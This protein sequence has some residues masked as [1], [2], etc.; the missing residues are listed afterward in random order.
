MGGPVAEPLGA[1]AEIYAALRT[2]L[3]DYTDKNGFERVVF[4]LSGGIDSALVAM[5]AVDALGAERVTCVVMPS[6]YSTDATQS[7]ARAIAANLGTELIEIAIEPAMQVYED[8]AAPTPSP[9]PS[10][11]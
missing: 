2:G 5:L 7:D 6:T 3:R 8:A 9:A 11:T 10:P 4:G 1:E